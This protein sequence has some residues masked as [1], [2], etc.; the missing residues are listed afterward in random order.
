MHELE[1]CL[2]TLRS[3]LGPRSGA[4][5]RL[6][7]HLPLPKEEMFAQLTEYIGDT[8]KPGRIGRRFPINAGIIG[9]AYREKDVFVGRRVNDDYEAYIR[10]LVKDWNY[11]E[12]RARKLHPGMREWMGVPI[13]DANK[14]RV[15][16]VLYLDSTEAQFFNEHR[17][18]VVLAAVNGIAVFIGKRYA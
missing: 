13:L 5:V 17:Q 11:T 6:A 12:D 8:P 18:E 2:Y 15:E 14:D 1:G 4:T 16:A 9:N 7:M 10:E 3:T